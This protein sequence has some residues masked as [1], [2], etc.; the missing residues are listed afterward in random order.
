MTWIAPDDR[1]VRDLARR[2]ERSM[3]RA[4]AAG[5][6]QRW[7][8]EGYWLLPLLCLLGLLWFRPGWVVQ[9]G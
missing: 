3:V 2:V 6:G 9:A 4:A 5:E 8:D 1:D 7:R